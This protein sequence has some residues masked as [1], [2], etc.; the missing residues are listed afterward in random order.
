MP[1]PTARPAELTS[2]AAAAIAALPADPFGCTD[3]PETPE[4][5]FGP[6]PIEKPLSA[7]EEREAAVRREVA[8]GFMR[9]APKDGTR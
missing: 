5:V 8:S 2:E 4:D 7:A 3:D 6:P 1:R 9:R